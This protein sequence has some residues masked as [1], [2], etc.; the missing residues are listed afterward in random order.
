M[1]SDY[2]PP[3]S[4]SSPSGGIPQGGPLTEDLDFNGF[5]AENVGTVTAAYIVA[6]S[7]GTTSL[8]GGAISTNGSGVMTAVSFSGIG[9]AIDL[10]SN[11][12]IIPDN[13]QGG[14]FPSIDIGNTY[15]SFTGNSPLSL[16]DI[17]TNVQAS[18]VNLDALASG[19]LN[20]TN[21]DFLQSNGDGS[22]LAVN[23]ETLQTILGNAQFAPSG[24]SG[25]LL[26]T[27]GD[28]S[29]LNL[30]SNTGDFGGTAAFAA[31]SGT[32]GFSSND[33]ATLHGTDNSTSGIA[34][35]QSDGSLAKAIGV[36]LKP[37]VANT[38]SGTGT[39]TTAF[40]V[41]IG[42][43]LADTNYT[44]QITPR[45]TLSSAVSNV[46]TKTTTSFTVTYLTGLTGAVV[47]DWALIPW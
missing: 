6:V 17:G 15:I 1:S 3:L 23:G 37:T 41:T 14:T 33:G 19:S 18:N 38:F 47:F 26:M 12:T 35:F 44:P 20:G 31:S 32:A 29:L 27:D 22:S 8:D 10:S 7:G 5:A 24:S 46:S 21:N 28:G 25:T 34:A 11:T 4:G 30:S 45:N 13:L 36:N 43:T 40:V 42:S 39:A 2:T 9:T 16:S